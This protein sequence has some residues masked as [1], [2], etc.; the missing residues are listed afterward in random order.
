MEYQR[1]AVSL[2][3]FPVKN[4]GISQ[5][6]NGKS[7]GLKLTMRTIP[8][9]GH[10]ELHASLQLKKVAPS[11]AVLTTPGHGS[12]PGLGAGVGLSVSSDATQGL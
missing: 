11:S 1:R 9:G 6:T 8:G 4:E 10:F 7:D 2:A 12:G 5:V 3:H